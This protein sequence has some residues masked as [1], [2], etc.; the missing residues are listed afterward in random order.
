MRARAQRAKACGHGE[1]GVVENAG[2]VAEQRAGVKD[3][4]PVIEPAWPSA[5]TTCF[6]NVLA[7]LVLRWANSA[8]SDVSTSFLS[9]FSP[10]SLSRSSIFKFAKRRSG[11]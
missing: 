5:W 2:D 7:L 8:R 1:D 9:R 3:Y 4:V 11:I 6:R 10:K